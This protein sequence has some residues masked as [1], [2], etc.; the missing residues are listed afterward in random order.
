VFAFEVGFG[1]GYWLEVGATCAPNR[2]EAC[3]NVYP[4]IE[5]F[6]FKQTVVG[7]VKVFSFDVDACEGQTLAGSLFRLLVNPADLT[8]PFS[9]FDGTTVHFQRAPK[10]F[11]RL[12]GRL[13]LHEQLR[14]EQ[15]CFDLADVLGL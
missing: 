8:E 1:S 4:T 10:A 5:L 11:N 7:S 14:I 2:F 12:V 3:C 9:Q 15:S 13:I 6:C